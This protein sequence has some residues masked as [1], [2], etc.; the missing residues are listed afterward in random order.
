MPFFGVVKG[1]SALA[2]VYETENDAS[3]RV[4]M[5]NNYQHIFNARGEMSPYCRLS[6]VTALWNPEM[7]RFG[8]SRGI[9]FKFVPDGN[10]VGIA[11]HYKKIA[12]EQGLAIK[13]RDKIQ[14]N[15]NIEKLFGA[16]LINFNGG[17]PWYVDH[18]AFRYTWNDVKKY[19]DDLRNYVGLKRSLLTLWI[20]YQNYP[21]DSHPF[22]PAQGTV[23][24]LQDLMKYA[25]D[26][27]YQICFYHGYPA[28]LDHAPNCDPYRA[29]K[30]PTG[31]M[32]SR[33]GR[34]CSS[35]YLEY[36]KK[37]LP[38][39]VKDS[40]QTAD[41]TDILTALGINECYENGHDHSRTQDRRMR[42]ELLQFINSLG[43]FTG[44]E[45]PQG[46]A[47]PNTA[48]FK[49]GGYAAYQ[50]IINQHLVPLFNLVYRDCNVMFRE[51][52]P[53]PDQRMMQDVAAGCHFQLHFDK[54]SYWRD[55]YWHTRESMKKAVEIVQDFNR[56][57][58]PEEL[59]THEWLEELNGPFRT[60]FSDG[61]EV[62]VNPLA[63]SREVDGKMFG[64]ETFLIKFSDGRRIEAT[65]RRDWI[66]SKQ[67]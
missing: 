62:L 13:L 8:Y 27:E 28:L 38:A 52:Y 29:T 60:R 39:S 56:H 44:S 46:W 35:F 10:Y 32:G 6:A 15:P 36:A 47:A 31:S 2:A 45:H 19:I 55:G 33:W 43:V 40:H 9:S 4:I 30:S 58:G 16:A 49:N 25:Y 48:Y 37:N 24:E 61:S 63:E 21:P 12:H 7:G 23:E 53:E 67:P 1:R 66:V 57:T 41:Y 26:R 20:G 3:V 5:N 50:W 59:L 11:K 65:Q 14:A 17:Y 34:H 54:D 64:P 22:H 42:T 51:F 18:P